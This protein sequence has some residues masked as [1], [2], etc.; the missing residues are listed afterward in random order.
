MLYKASIYLLVG[1]YI[2][3]QHRVGSYSGGLS[4]GGR[5]SNGHYGIKRDIIIGLVLLLASMPVI[6]SACGPGAEYNQAQAELE[7]ISKKNE[8]LE[9]AIQERRADNQRL[10]GDLATARKE[11]AAAQSETVVVQGRIEELQKEL[12][13]ENSKLLSNQS[14]FEYVEWKIEQINNKIEAIKKLLSQY[15]R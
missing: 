6:T 13:S 7:E 14:E 1:R 12:S 10:E 11:L 15:K 2:I 5:M 4:I 9:K 8:A 3:V